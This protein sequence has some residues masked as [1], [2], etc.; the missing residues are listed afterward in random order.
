MQPIVMIPARRAARRLPDKPLADI[1]GRALILHVLDRAHEAALGPVVVAAGDAGIVEA[2]LADGGAAVLTDPDL[3]SG[4]DRIYAALAEADPRGAHD[5]IVNLQGDLPFIDPDA[6]RAVL[7]PLED[8][9]TDIA[10]LVAPIRSAAEA[11]DPNVVKAV[12]GLRDGETVGRTHYFSRAA[13]PAGEGPLYHHIGVYAYRRAALERFV[14][15]PQSVLERRERLEQLRALQAGM[16]IAAALVDTVPDAVDTP[17]D[18][19]RL[20]ARVSG[21]SADA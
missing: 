9:A 3:P 16:V 4:S 21:T 10:T 6:L 2:V 17:A 1:G 15:L 14:A 12:L 20:R 19:A 5:V 11:D 13:V 7:K 18:L 8:P